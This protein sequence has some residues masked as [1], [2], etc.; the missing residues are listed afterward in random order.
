MQVISIRVASSNYSVQCKVTKCTHLFRS[1]DGEIDDKREEKREEE[2]R[3]GGSLG[4]VQEKWRRRVSGWR[5]SGSVMGADELGRASWW[6]IY[7]ALDGTLARYLSS[8]SRLK[9]G[10]MA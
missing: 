4:W 6:Y 5:R 2:R 10:L 1:Q 3:M 8:A 7:L 9:H